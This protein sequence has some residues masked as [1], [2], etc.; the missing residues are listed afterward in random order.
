MDCGWSNSSLACDGGI[1]GVAAM[2]LIDRF[3][4]RVPTR[5]VYG[6][7]LSVD[8]RCY[9][10]ILESIGM[11]ER[12]ASTLSS[13]VQFTDWVVI[14]T[15]DDIA[16]KH[17]LLNHGPLSVGF[18]VVD[19]SLYYADGVLDVSSCS[20]TAEIN[21]DHEVVLVGWG[22]D[23]LADGTQME[24][25]VLRNSW[26]TL[27]GDSGYLNVRMGERDC[28]VTTSAGFPLVKKVP[29]TL[30]LKSDIVDK[31]ILGSQ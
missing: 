10:D 12:V 29:H 8:G 4:G 6:G 28:G 3:H 23:D 7:Y 22:V 5:E 26:S 15:R 19:E 16:I 13:T 31:G 11:M 17:A 1:V 14:P 27:W 30:S 20:A 21:L 18:N 2:Q 24:H 25:W 9:T